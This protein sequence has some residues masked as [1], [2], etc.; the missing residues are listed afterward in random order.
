MQPGISL[1]GSSACL[2]APGMLKSWSVYLLEVNDFGRKLLDESHFWFVYCILISCSFPLLITGFNQILR[3][4][5]LR[6]WDLPLSL[7]H[8][9][10]STKNKPLDQ[11]IPRF[12]LE[13]RFDDFSQLHADL[14]ELEPGMCLCQAVGLC[15]RDD[16][17]KWHYEMQQVFIPIAKPIF[18]TVILCWGVVG[19]LHV[20]GVDTPP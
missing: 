15:N 8:P 13:K 17:G 11:L 5:I 7:Y 18:N 6:D 20:M 9:M 19:R 12:T 1:L 16:D 14:K 10:F 2:G 3:S 4:W